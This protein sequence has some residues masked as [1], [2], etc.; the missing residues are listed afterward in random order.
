MAFN[1][2]WGLEWGPLFKLGQIFGLEFSNVH[3]VSP[4]ICIGLVK[5]HGPLGI[6][7]P[8]HFRGYRFCLMILGT[9]S[10][11]GSVASCAA[12]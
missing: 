3:E 10:G 7:G 11:N 12:N 2:F 9:K 8:V 4:I 1:R 6:R 5:G